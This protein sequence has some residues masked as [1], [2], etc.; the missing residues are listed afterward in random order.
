M[1]DILKARSTVRSEGSRITSILKDL[2][3]NG[4][5]APTSVAEADSKEEKGKNA[6]SDFVAEK[7]VACPGNRTI[8]KSTDSTNPDNTSIIY[9]E[10]SQSPRRLFGYY[11]SV[12][13]EY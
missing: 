8:V 6:S 9:H 13:A 5:C 4:L 7:K 12:P 3:K 11:C 10:P 2:R 1:H